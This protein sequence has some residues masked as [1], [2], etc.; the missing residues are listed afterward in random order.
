MGKE[1]GVRKKIHVRTES[2]LPGSSY[3][4]TKQNAVLV[5]RA[6]GSTHTALLCPTVTERELSPGSSC[7]KSSSRVRHKLLSSISRAWVLET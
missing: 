6:L 5:F 4:G 1:K 3:E 7:D 2:P